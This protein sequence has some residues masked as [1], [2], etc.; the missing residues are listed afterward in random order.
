MQIPGCHPTPTES[1]ARVWPKNLHFEEP[2]PPQAILLLGVCGGLP[3][4]RE[5]SGVFTL[6]LCHRICPAP[7]QRGH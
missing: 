1:Q 4:C 7:V 6:W 5:F 2:P 3:L